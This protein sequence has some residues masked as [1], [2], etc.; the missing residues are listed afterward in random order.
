[1]VHC[2]YC[3]PVTEKACLTAYSEQ[4]N[5]S[6]FFLQFRVTYILGAFNAP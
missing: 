6:R 2:V 4:K 3:R 5:I 1:M